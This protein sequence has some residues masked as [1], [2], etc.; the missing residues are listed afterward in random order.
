MTRHKL[1]YSEEAL[2]HLDRLSDFLVQN[3]GTQTA[4]DVISELINSFDILIEM[5][6]IGREH[7]DPMLA[8]RGYR[9]LFIGR[10]ACVYIVDNKEVWIAGVYYTKSDWI[11]RYQPNE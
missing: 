3:A 4:F 9:V 2:S 11:M 5:P 7:P 1:T 6:N 10:Y 8:N